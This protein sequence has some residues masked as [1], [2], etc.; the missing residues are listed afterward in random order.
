MKKVLVTGFA[1]V[2]IATA[3]FGIGGKNS[4]ALESNNV[5]NNEEVVFTALDENLKD[6]GTISDGIHNTSMILNSSLEHVSSFSEIKGIENIEKYMNGVIEL[7]EER[8]AAQ[9]IKDRLN[10]PNQL[11]QQAISEQD[12]NKLHE[13][14]KILLDLDLEFNEGVSH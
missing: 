13:A 9:L 6:N 3:W 7:A 14:N 2:V 11:I 12:I 4:E 5:K 8:N 1:S 10:Q